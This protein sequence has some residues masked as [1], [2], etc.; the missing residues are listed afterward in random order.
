MVVVY[1]WHRVHLLASWWTFSPCY[2]HG[3]SA[4][5]VIGQSLAVQERVDTSGSSV[6][7][8]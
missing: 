7:M 2:R 5:Q 3:Y 1:I 6:H 8:A 4:S